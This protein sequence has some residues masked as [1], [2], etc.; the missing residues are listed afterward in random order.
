MGRNKL[1]DPSARFN[2]PFLLVTN[3][4]VLFPIIKKNWF[5]V[6]KVENGGLG[7]GFGYGSLFWK[8]EKGNG[9]GKWRGLHFVS[10]KWRSVVWRAGL[11]MS[12]CFGGKITSMTIN[13]IKILLIYIKQND[14]QGKLPNPKICLSL[15]TNSMI[16]IHR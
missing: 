5:H 12:L 3:R 7:S 6:T 10:Q 1:K 16:Q 15:C 11:A 8:K 2:S 13:N 9:G 14:S 4:L